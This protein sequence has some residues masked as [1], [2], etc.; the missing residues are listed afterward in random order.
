MNISIRWSFLCVSCLH[1][2]FSFAGG[3][4]DA[5]RRGDRE[6]LE[7]LLNGPFRESINESNG[8][9]SPLHFAV[10]LGNKEAV[11]LLIAYGADIEKKEFGSTPLF[12]AVKNGDEGMVRLLLD[13]GAQQ[14]LT[15]Q[16]SEEQYTALH[17]AALHDRCTV[18]QLLLAREFDTETQVCRLGTPL[19]CAAYKGKERVTQLLLDCKVNIDAQNASGYTPLHVAVAE[20]HERVVRLL[21]EYGADEKVQNSDRCNPLDIAKTYRLFKLLLAFGASLSSYDRWDSP[22][23]EKLLDFHCPVGTLKACA[24]RACIRNHFDIDLLCELNLITSDCKEYVLS[25]KWMDGFFIQGRDRRN[26]RLMGIDELIGRL[27]AV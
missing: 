12:I 17:V 9:F 13:G 22:D 15:E 6:R 27:Y 5:I 14:V 21:L 2:T 10:R 8:I 20:G 23:I 26:K 4:N 1:L 18:A 3:L 19:H 24:A 25:D 7:R 11:R 16:D